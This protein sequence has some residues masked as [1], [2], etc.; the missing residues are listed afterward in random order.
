VSLV[1]VIVVLFVVVLIV[2]APLRRAGQSEPAVSP[3][4]DDL[5][6]A[7]QAKY[8]EIKDAELDHRTGKLS[9]EDYHVLDDGL[10]AEAIG[11]MRSIDRERGRSAS[12]PGD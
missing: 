5:E 12:A 4:L 8:R 3:E 11:I 6:A 10:R 9:D 7:R 2:S 1:L